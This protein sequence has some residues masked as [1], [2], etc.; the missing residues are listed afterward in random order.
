[1]GAT[2]IQRLLFGCAGEYCDLEFAVEV[3][4]RK[5]EEEG[6][7]AD[8]KSN[9]PPDRWGKIFLTCLECSLCHAPIR[10]YEI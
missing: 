4:R 2:L 8:I 9:N 3:R 1:M 5:E 10:S 7:P 6:R